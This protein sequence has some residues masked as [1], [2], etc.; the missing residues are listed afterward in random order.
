MVAVSG[1]MVD[2]FLVTGLLA[3]LAYAL[4]MLSRSGALGGFVVGAAIYLCLGPPGFVVL[5]LF[6]V[7]G[8]AL[9]RL[10]YRSKHRRGVAQ[11]HGGRRGASNALANCGVAL[12]CAVLATLIPSEAFAAA[13]VA[14]L[15]AA[16]GDTA[17]SEVGQLAC[18]TPR[19]I[20]TLRKV[21]PGTDGA[22]SV[23]GTLAGLA[24]AG[25]TAFLGLMLG[26]VTES[27]V[28]LLVALASF[29]GT[30]ADSFV[31]ALVPRV[32]NELTNVLCTLVAAALV[33]FLA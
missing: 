31:G 10:G 26:L 18:S 23:T 6:V 7:G 20:T 14:A 29:L 1:S 32:G 8:S 13:F 33:L 27:G 5:A 9:T 15:G 3:G 16:F 11:D 2:A 12:L 21:P 19:L 4:K 25:L 17:E 28:A 30:V 22:V 24:V